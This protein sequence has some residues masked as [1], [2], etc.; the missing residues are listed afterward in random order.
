MDSKEAAALTDLNVRKAERVM[1]AQWIGFGLVSSLF[2]G[3]VS[4]DYDS[5]PD[6][7]IAT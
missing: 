4:L 6:S 5:D 2:Y 3:F 7:C 1:S